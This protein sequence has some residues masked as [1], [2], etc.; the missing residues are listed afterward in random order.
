MM[1]DAQRRCMMPLKR[2]F[3]TWT[4]DGLGRTSFKFRNVFVVVVLCKDADMNKIHY[5]V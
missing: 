4:S 5:S 2:C 1:R 3:V